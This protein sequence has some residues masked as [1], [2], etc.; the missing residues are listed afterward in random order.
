MISLWNQRALW[1][2]KCYCWCY[3]SPSWLIMIKVFKDS[4]GCSLIHLRTL[5][6]DFLDILYSSSFFPL[7]H[8]ATRVT[9]NSVTLIDNI[10]T[11]SLSKGS[12]EFCFPTCLTIFQC[13]LVEIKRAENTKKMVQKRIMSKSNICKCK[14]FPT[15]IPWEDL[16]VENNT[17]FPHQKF[18]KVSN[19][20]FNECFPI[21]S[22]KKSSQVGKP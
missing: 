17:D 22:T 11:N 7:I 9:E 8:K 19:F 10:L 2:T 1:W 13:L 3:V 14:D 12:L 5:T 21:Y 4:L 20:G 18:V 15:S 16:Y 6:G